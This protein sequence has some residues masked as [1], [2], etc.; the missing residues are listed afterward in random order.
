LSAAAWASVT[1]V[2]SLIVA[3]IASLFITSKAR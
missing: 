3:L 2:V 1:A